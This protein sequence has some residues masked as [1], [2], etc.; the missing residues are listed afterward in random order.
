MTIL[1]LS[2]FD[3]IIFSLFSNYI[4]IPTIALERIQCLGFFRIHACGNKY[5]QWHLFQGIKTI[6]IYNLKLFLLET[7]LFFHSLF[8]LGIIFVLQGYASFDKPSF[9]ILSKGKVSNLRSAKVEGKKSPIFMALY[10]EIEH[11]VKSIRAYVCKLVALALLLGFCCV[12]F[13]F[14]AG[15][16]I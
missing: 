7:H 4:K 14:C 16:I 6:D 1:G 8:L 13:M 10:Q 11:L 15:Y 9:A 3:I 2:I 5:Y 12:L